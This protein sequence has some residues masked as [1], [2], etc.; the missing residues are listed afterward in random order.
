MEKNNNPQEQPTVKGKT[1]RLTI[2]QAKAQKIVNIKLDD[3]ALPWLRR[4]F[5]NPSEYID[6]E[7]ISL[8]KI[9]VNISVLDNTMDV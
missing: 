3:E 7:N 2:L 9:R 5:T 8:R 6:T 4:V 1:L